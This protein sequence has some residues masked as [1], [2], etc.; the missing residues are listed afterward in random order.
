MPEQTLKPHWQVGAA[1]L[2]R[3]ARIS[4]C[5]RYRYRL[6]REWVAPLFHQEAPLKTTCF[7]ML[8]PSTADAEIDDPTIRRCI[9]FAQAWGYQAL[10]VVN[11]FAFRATD[12]TRLR[13]AEDPI[14][15]ENDDQIAISALSSLLVVCAW[16]AWGGYLGR[17]EAVRRDLAR[18]GKIHHLG[19]T[20]DG[21]PKHPLYLRA[22][23]A[24]QLWETM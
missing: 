13:L 19:L 2:R 5:G 15:P 24:P 12:P 21:H 23:T 9:G 6:R 20:K 4:D 16:G 1:V 3:D 8:N 18:L 11:L 7:V 14:G 10:D 17:G 22:D